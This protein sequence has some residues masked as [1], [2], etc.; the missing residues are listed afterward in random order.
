MPCIRPCFI[1]FHHSDSFDKKLVIDGR[2]D[3]RTDKQ[4]DGKT[5][6]RRDG[7]RDGQTDGRKELPTRAT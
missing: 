3:G 7:W 4:M 6:E 2:M 1:H 5:D